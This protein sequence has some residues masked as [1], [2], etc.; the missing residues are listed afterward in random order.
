[1]KAYLLL[2]AISVFGNGITTIELRMIW[3]ILEIVDSDYRYC[4]KHLTI[5]KN[6]D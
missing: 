5:D 1:M 6:N 4:L 3:E 2:N